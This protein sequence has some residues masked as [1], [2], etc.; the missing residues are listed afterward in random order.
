MIGKKEKV[1][2]KDSTKFLD[3]ILAKTQDLLLWH[4][5]SRD[6]HHH[7]TSLTMLSQLAIESPRASEGKIQGGA[8]PLCSRRFP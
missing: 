6:V 2:A 5:C 4:I 3:V 8:C 1:S 7:H